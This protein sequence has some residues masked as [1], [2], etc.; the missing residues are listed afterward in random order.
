MTESTLSS[1]AL[2]S[3]LRP[4]ARRQERYWKTSRWQSS[5]R[6]T[7]LQRR[8]DVFN[9]RLQADALPGWPRPSTV[10]AD[11]DLAEN[12]ALRDEMESAEDRL[13]SRLTCAEQLAEHWHEIPYEHL[14]Q[15]KA[16]Q[17]RSELAAAASRAEQHAIY[18]PTNTQSFHGSGAHSRENSPPSLDTKVLLINTQNFGPRPSKGAQPPAAGGVDELDF[19][20]TTLDGGAGRFDPFKST[21][22]APPPAIE[23]GSRASTSRWRRSPSGRK[24]AR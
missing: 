23:S 5:A 15:S 7:E 20:R 21:K 2:G 8:I 11:A 22:S 16:A 17:A 6:V 3:R 24:S 1:E 4:S 12:L 19:R 13:E 14:E 10:A 9:F 18:T